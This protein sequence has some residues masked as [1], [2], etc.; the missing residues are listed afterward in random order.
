MTVAN[1]DD[2]VALASIAALLLDLISEGGTI[3]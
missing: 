1:R 2:D 3:I